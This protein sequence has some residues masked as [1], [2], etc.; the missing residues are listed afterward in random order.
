MEDMKIRDNT[1]IVWT[2]DNGSTAS[3]TNTMNG[4][5][6]NGGKTKTTENGIN[7]PFIVSCPGIVPQGKTTDALVDFTDM[8][9][10]FAELGGI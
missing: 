5:S 10:I 8:L 7:A 1:I 3:L 9:P 4:R 6:V 2:T